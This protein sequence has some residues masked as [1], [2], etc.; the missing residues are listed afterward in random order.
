MESVGIDVV[1]LTFG[2]VFLCIALYGRMETQWFKVGS[3]S[4]IVRAA[5]GAV[6]LVLISIA[7]IKAE[8]LPLGNAAK[9]AQLTNDNAVLKTTI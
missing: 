9:L 6:G 8:V 7:L 2:A 4:S 5:S 1:L 3:D